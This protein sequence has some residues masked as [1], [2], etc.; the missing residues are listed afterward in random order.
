MVVFY[1]DTIY[2][3]NNNLLVSTTINCNF[4]VDGIISGNVEIGLP[5][6]HWL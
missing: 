3:N 1:G 6:S 4:Q 2:N 5:Q